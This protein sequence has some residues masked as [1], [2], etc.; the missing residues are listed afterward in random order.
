MHGVILQQD[1]VS[2]H[3]VGC[4]EAGLILV[5]PTIWITDN[6]RQKLRK[7]QSHEPRKSHSTHWNL[8]TT[9]YRC[10]RADLGGNWTQRTGR[11]RSRLWWRSSRCPGIPPPSWW[12]RPLPSTS[13]R[14]GTRGSSLPTRGTGP[15]PPP[16]RRLEYR[17]ISWQ[18]S[19]RSEMHLEIIHHSSKTILKDTRGHEELTQSMSFL[20]INS[21]CFNYSSWH[22]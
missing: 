9:Y 22:S 16:G 12:P 20:A 17:R 3:V 7:S 11:R 15:W 8:R 13:G 1:V 4:P 18:W 5:P 10:P 6:Q 14:A 2:R 21:I 19:R